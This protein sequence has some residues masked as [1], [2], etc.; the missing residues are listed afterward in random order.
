MTVDHIFPRTQ[1]GGNS[2]LNLVGCC[3]RCNERKGG[4][5]PEEAGMPLRYQPHEPTPLMSVL[6]KNDLDDVPEEWKAYF[7]F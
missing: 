3:K 6:R 7:Y 5:T 2:W 1:G 4:K